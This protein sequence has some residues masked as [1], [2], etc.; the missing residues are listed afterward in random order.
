M[1]IGL[2]QGHLPVEERD[3]CALCLYGLCIVFRQRECEVWVDLPLIVV[4]RP[5][6]FG[7]VLCPPHLIEVLDPVLQLSES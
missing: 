5:V 7:L 4:G 2:R 3:D 6:V 1:P